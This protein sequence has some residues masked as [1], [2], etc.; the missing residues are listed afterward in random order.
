DQLEMHPL[1]Q[2]AD[3]VMRLDQR[4]LAGRSTRGLDHV[5]IDRALR[6]PLDAF[7][8]LRLG[9]EDLDEE[10]ADDLALVLRILHALERR[11]ELLLRVDAN[12]IDAEM[13]AEHGHDLIALAEAQE[14]MVD[15]HA[16]E[17]IADRRMEQR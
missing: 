16:D 4:R 7:E 2:P 1:R 8:P 14:T 11:E 9:L 6:E 12:H 10:P 13:L 5:G 17:L 3:V 15:E